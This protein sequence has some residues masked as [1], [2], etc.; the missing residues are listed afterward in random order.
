MQHYPSAKHAALGG[1]QAAGEA[2]REE[3]WELCLGGNQLFDA[4]AELKEPVG[5]A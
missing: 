5:R 2:G 1:T 4:A 3:P